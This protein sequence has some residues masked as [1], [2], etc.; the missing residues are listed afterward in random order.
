MRLIDAEDCPP[1][2][3]ASSGKVLL[4]TGLY[5]RE[6]LPNINMFSSP[7]RLYRQTH[8]VGKA[9]YLYL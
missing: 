4:K 7:S 9:M 8:Y 5:I 6:L 1:N 3:E 2:L